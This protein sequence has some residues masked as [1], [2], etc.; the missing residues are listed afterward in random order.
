MELLKVGDDAPD[1]ET[2][3]QDGKKVR[4]GDYKD[5]TVVLYFYPKDNTPGCTVEAKNFR[6]NIDIFKQNGIDIFGMSVDSQES[7]KKFQGK[8]DLNFTLLSDKD[9]R[10][11]REYGVL[12]LAVAKRVTYIIKN[13][14]I[15]Y[16]FEKVTPKDHAKEVFDRIKEL[17]L[18]N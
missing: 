2:V 6:D 13:G 17:N 7:H 16:V 14:K 1:F 18:V 8:F 11:T 15:M 9:K 10:I 4:L 5:K 3:D 12:G